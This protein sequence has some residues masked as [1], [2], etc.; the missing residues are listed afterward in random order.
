MPDM[1]IHYSS[2]EVGLRSWKYSTY[3]CSMKKN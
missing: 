2:E 3:K 1:K